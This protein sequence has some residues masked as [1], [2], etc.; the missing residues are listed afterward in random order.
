MFLTI[1]SWC[2]MKVQLCLV[3]DIFGNYSGVTMIELV[4]VEPNA[5]LFTRLAQMRGPYHRGIS[6]W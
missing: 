6:F 2:N 3:D 1:G 5:F 4:Y